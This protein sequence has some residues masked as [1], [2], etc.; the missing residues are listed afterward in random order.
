[1]QVTEAGAVYDVVIVGSVNVNAGFQLVGNPRYPG[2]AQDFQRTF[3]TLKALHCDIFLGAHG[4]YYGL[5]GKFARVPAQGAKVFVDP[6][7]YSADVAEREKAFV[8]E[9][10]RQKR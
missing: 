1:M 9:L 8:Q 5:E 7:G 10:E 2:I 6:T 3:A 4:D